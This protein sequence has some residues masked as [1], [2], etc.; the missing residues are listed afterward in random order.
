[1]KTTYV[2]A[3]A[4]LLLMSCNARFG[5]AAESQDT[6]QPKYFLMMRTKALPGMRTE[7]LRVLKT[8]V[9]PFTRTQGFPLFKSFESVNHPGEFLFLAPCRGYAD[10]LKVSDSGDALS[11]KLYRLA[12]VADLDLYELGS[13]SMLVDPKHD[14]PL[15]MLY[16]DMVASGRQVENR[17]IQEDELA[18]A[19]KKGGGKNVHVF[20]SEF[21]K[22]SKMT[23]LFDFDST[24]EMED[25]DPLEKGLGS[26]AAERNV[27]GRYFATLTSRDRELF[28][29]L[30]ELSYRTVK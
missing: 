20:Y 18:P 9:I 23:I 1:M 13:T 6:R 15:M 7:Y 30:P 2:H 16:E 3:A 28:R 8:E 12:A 19:W 14:A 25:A 22:S 29:F 24:A 5:F 17:H 21:G 10:L 4:A 27:M 11:E 26:A